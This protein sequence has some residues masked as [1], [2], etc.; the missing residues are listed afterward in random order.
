[1]DLIFSSFRVGLDWLGKLQPFDSFASIPYMVSF[2]WHGPYS[3]LVLNH[4]STTT[5]EL[6]TF[7]NTFP[8][9]SNYS[10]ALFKFSCNLHVFILC[11][12]NVWL[13]I[14][15]HFNLFETILPTN[16]IFFLRLLCKNGNGVCIS[17]PEIFRN[18]DT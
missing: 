12:H 15:F 17:G 14:C 3:D 4:V 7:S 13:V 18:P 1:M 6:Q 5:T 8:T 9:V 11:C 2:W 16:A 10:N